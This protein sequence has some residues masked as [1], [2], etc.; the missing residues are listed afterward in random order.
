M[1]VEAGRDC[2]R[3][4][5]RDRIAALSLASSTVPYADLQNS[6]IVAGALDLPKTVA[7]SERRNADTRAP[8]TDS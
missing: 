8:R 4:I 1:A 5:E 7:T 6:V 3:G 2:L